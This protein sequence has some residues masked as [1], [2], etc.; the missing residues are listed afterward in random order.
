M[1]HY[2]TAGGLQTCARL[3]QYIHTRRQWHT[4][5]CTVAY[6]LYVTL[7]TT[8]LAQSSCIWCGQ[9]S[10]VQA[11]YKWPSIKENYSVQIYL[12][13][14]FLFSDSLPQAEISTI[15]G[16]RYRTRADIQYTVVDMVSRQETGLSL[17]EYLFV[18]R[19]EGLVNRPRVAL[20]L[21]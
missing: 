1:A 16:T 6:I 5:H 8:T 13:I 21:V 15:S 9:I 17:G 18:E 2:R 11:H 12:L 4:L 7:I 3:M 14:F 20:D 19:R 10:T